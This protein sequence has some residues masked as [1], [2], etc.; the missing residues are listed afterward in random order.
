VD[1]HQYLAFHEDVERA[2]V[3]A[4]RR[5]RLSWEDAQDFTGYAR[6][7]LLEDDCRILRTFRGQNRQAYLA[8]VM[9][10]L[11]LD[12]RIKEW[13]KWR[14]SAEARRHGGAAVLFEALV[15]REG[16]TPHEAAAMLSFR[17]S[18][19]APDVADK[20]TRR[21]PKPRRVP[22]IEGH[23]ATSFVALPACGVSARERR[24]TAVRIRRVLADAIGRLPDQERAILVRRFWSSRTIS[25]LARDLEM[26]P[27]LLYRKLDSTLEILRKTLLAAGIAN[28]DVTEAMTEPGI[29]LSPLV[30]PSDCAA[31]PPDTGS[32][33]ARLLVGAAAS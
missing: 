18:A 24:T 12:Y 29:D 17:G 14:S 28:A 13:G 22:E 2:L 10:R 20:L 7:R 21:M 26:P 9:R 4:A 6:V 33:K 32:I 31:N 23:L 5:A 8:I 15:Y 11:M 30:A 19:L 27:K 1:A 3:R 16:Y 25:E